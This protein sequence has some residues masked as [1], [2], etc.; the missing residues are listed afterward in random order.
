MG[1]CRRNAP[2]SH[3]PTDEQVE[4]DERYYAR[5]PLTHI[6]LDWCGE[7]KEKEK[8]KENAP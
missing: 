7:F 4:N 3:Y 2:V 8:D 5:F 1:Q 6:L